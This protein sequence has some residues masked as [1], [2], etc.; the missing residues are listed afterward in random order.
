MDYTPLSLTTIARL[1][2]GRPSMDWW[3][4]SELFVH[5]CTKS[6]F[7]DTLDDVLGSQRTSPVVRERLLD[8]LAA[9]AY[10]STGPSHKTESSFRLLCCGAWQLIGYRALCNYY[11]HSRLARSCD[12]G[13]HWGSRYDR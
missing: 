1:H 4:S 9:A 13:R 7:L 10:A 2:R 8:V 3:D 11:R 5:Q 6:K 12:Y